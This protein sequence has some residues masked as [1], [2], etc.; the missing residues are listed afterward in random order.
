MQAAAQILAVLLFPLLVTT[1]GGQSLAIGAA[2][3]R[4]GDTVSVEV[5]LDV[6]LDCA[7]VLL[8]LEFD[9]SILEHPVVE[10]GD[11]L[12]SGH[13]IDFF[14]PAEGRLNVFVAGLSRLESLTARTGVVVR[15]GFRIRQGTTA[16]FSDISPTQSG[17]P[18]LPSSNLL[19]SSGS[20][21]VHTVSPGRIIVDHSLSDLWMLQ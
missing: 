5:T 19:D 17:L 7:G 8:R 14:S 16:S 13:L 3:S 9:P 18:E 2:T 4:P 21:I 1:V 10:R 12:T 6:P 11:I 15:L 20:S